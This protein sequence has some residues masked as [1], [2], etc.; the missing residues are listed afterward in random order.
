VEPPVNEKKHAA[1][2]TT[3]LLNLLARL[4]RDDSGQDIVEYALIAVF[5]GLSTVVGVHGLASSI[6][7][8]LTTIL[9]AFS[10]ATAGAG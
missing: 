1:I 10:N 6:S 2:A 5:M 8:D 4:Y 3:S 9:N 7:N